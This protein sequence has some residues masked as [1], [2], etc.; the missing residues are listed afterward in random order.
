MQEHCQHF[1]KEDIKKN[2]PK[3]NYFTKK[4]VLQFSLE[5]QFFERTFFSGFPNPFY[6]NF[7][8]AHFLY[9]MVS[10]RQDRHSR[11]INS[12]SERETLRRKKYLIYSFYVHCQLHS[13]SILFKLKIKGKLV[14][15]VAKN[16]QKNAKK[17]A[18]NV[19]FLKVS[20]L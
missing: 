19:Y 3:K 1:V 18:K 11:G 17:R 15:R 5:I 13:L 8:L 12:F 7:S 4:N 6:C 10:I 20:L 9:P 14:E 2:I 16:E